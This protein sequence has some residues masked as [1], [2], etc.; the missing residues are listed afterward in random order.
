[1]IMETSESTQRIRIKIACEECRK[2]KRKVQPDM[3]PRAMLFGYLFPVSVMAR[4]PLAFC[5]QS[6][7]GSVNMPLRSRGSR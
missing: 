6:R 4:G 5:A 1:M 7:G 3:T 2:N